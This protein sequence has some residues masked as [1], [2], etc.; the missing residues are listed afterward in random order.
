MPADKR[1]A[2]DT[3]KVVRLGQSGDGV[4]DTPRGAVYVP[5]VLPGETVA[6]V[7]GVPGPVVGPFSPD[8]RQPLCTHVARC[9]GCAVQHLAAAPYRTWKAGLLTEALAAVGIAM[10]PLPMFVVPLRSR[11]RAVLSARRGGRD[12]IVGFHRRRSDD[13]EPIVDCAILT[14]G[15]VAALPGLARLAVD[16]LPPDIATHV[17][18]IE[19]GAGLDVAFETGR[20]DLSADAH[21]RLADTAT[22]SRFAR[23]SAAG[24][25]MV[26]R[27]APVLD[28]AGVAVVPPPGAFIQAAAA[29]ESHMAGLVVEALG[30]ARRVA[31]LFSGLGT[32]AFAMARRA[33]VL[34]VDGSR[35][36]IEALDKA[37]RGAAGL[38]PIEGKVRDLLLDPMSPR[39]L[40]TLD[41]VVFDPPRSGAKAQAEALARS[42]VPVV[43]AVSCN[44]QT[45]ARDLR[46][47]V[48]G[49]YNLKTVTPVDQFLFTPHLEAVAVL[50][51]PKRR[52]H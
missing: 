15:I 14:P 19:T 34:A 49:G 26:I 48:D 2:T 36:L 38:K 7:D 4:V 10:T 11:R 40:A 33:S 50:T 51:K 31:D 27:Q 41:A 47:L 25:P 44:P 23:V 42:D 16:L 12:A 9:G 21:Q 28:M 46:I 39:E 24:Y 1:S 20:K 37:Q 8:R 3:A 52:R 29:A 18:V 32:F 6:L 13:I 45:L 30:K 43:V 5:G 35:D 22:A 17:T